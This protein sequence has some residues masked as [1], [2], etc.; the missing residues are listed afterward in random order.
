MMSFFNDYLI[1]PV[2]SATT[3]YIINP[4]INWVTNKAKEIF[5][6][7]A[8]S[9]LSKKAVKPL[10]DNEIDPIDPNGN[11]MHFN[12][13]PLERLNELPQDIKRFG[14]GLAVEQGANVAFKTL[15]YLNPTPGA[16]ALTYIAPRAMRLSSTT[17]VQ[18]PSFAKTILCGA[19]S[20]ALSTLAQES[21]DALLPTCA[22][23]GGYVA[24]GLTNGISQIGLET[25]YN[26]ATA[27]LA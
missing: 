27:R 7:Q 2:Q 18:S 20:H 19:G 12:Q 4:T 22:P 1:A 9:T 26:K 21:T 8:V 14:K 24:Y 16:K 10:L 15:N 13:N 3:N 5:T 11:A 6:K 23:Y 25:I 17:N